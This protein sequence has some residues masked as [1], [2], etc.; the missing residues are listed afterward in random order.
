MSLLSEDEVAQALAE[1]PWERDGDAIVREREFDDFAA[2]IRYVNQIAEAAEAAN[3]HPDI[4]VHGWNKVR[5]ELS[6]HSEG[7]ITQSDI[8]MA[9]TLDSVG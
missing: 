9:R 8:D 6:T 7:G 2:A 4:L 1:S 3:H 5:L